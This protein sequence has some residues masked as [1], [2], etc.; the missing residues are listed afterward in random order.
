M[1]VYLADK[2]EVSSID[3][4]WRIVVSRDDTNLVRNLTLAGAK[5][6][7][8]TWTGSP[9]GHV[10][11]GADTAEAVLRANWSGASDP[12]V[13]DDTAD[14]YGVGSVWTTTAG[15]VWQ[16][17]DATL[18]AAV[19]KDLTATTP[20]AGSGTEL[21]LR[22]SASAFGALTGSSSANGGIALV[23]QA[24]GAVPLSITLASGQTAN[25]FQVTSSGGTAG[26]LVSI[27][28]DGTVKSSVSTAPWYMGR[29]SGANGA[30]FALDGS[31]N[32]NLLAANSYE[33]ALVSPNILRGW[34]AFVFQWANQVWDG[35]QLVNAT[36]DLGLAR[37]A[38]GAAEFNNGT[39][40]T[41]R[42]VKLRKLDATEGVSAGPVTF[43]VLNATSATATLG[44]Y[45]ITDRGNKL[46]YPDGTNWRFVGDD[47]IIS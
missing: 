40:G 8:R 7:F 38:E 24:I 43:A 15:K 25:A 3:S 5:T 21:Q 13:G 39:P 45:R 34:S 23:S 26:D 30:G 14:G 19:W 1:S 4:N 44:I 6:V 18:G 2:A 22:G 32:L 16:C 37:N 41:Y 12:T 27:A 31:G 36:A 11:V 33:T 28:K 17:T 35:S 47:A 42:D 9:T 29:F 46:A 20:P 10:V